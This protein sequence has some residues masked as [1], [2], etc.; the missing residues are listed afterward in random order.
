MKLTPL[1]KLCI[2]HAC[3]TENEAK[4]QNQSD[5][6]ATLLGYVSSDL[7]AWHQFGRSQDNA[8][9]TTRGKSKDKP[10]NAGLW[11]GLFTHV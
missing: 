1:K 11:T 10:L 8:N 9:Q 4:H 6:S 3:H 2:K 5:I 7:R